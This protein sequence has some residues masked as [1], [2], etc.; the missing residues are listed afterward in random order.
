MHLGL[1]LSP[2]LCA[3]PGFDTE[4][5]ASP[6]CVL[7]C[8]GRVINGGSSNSVDSVANIYLLSCVWDLDGSL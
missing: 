1:R 6:V 3:L 7:Y 4:V 8:I 2:S 5:E